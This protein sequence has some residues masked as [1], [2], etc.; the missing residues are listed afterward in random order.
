MALGTD[1]SPGADTPTDTESMSLTSRYARLD[2]NDRLLILSLHE[3]AKPQTEIARIVGCSQSTVSAVIKQATQTPE[4]VRKLART[5]IPHFIQGMVDAVEPAA[6]RGDSTPALKGL[7]LAHQELG[8]QAGN[9]SGLGGVTINIGAPGQ[10]LQPPA[11]DI[12]VIRPALSPPVTEV[13]HSLTGD[14]E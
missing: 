13:I 7:A 2:V 9:T 10:P 3:A 8:A 11:L 12:Q 14:S 6:K 1:L 4:A 5:Y